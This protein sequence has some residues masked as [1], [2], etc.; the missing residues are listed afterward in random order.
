MINAYTQ[1]LQ[2]VIN[3]LIEGIKVKGHLRLAASTIIDNTLR[4][5]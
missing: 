4:V 2:P 1:W 3:A 5:L